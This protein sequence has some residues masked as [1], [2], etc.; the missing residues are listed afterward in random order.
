[1]RAKGDAYWAAQTQALLLEAQGWRS[2]AQGDAGSA[3]AS[4]RAA[5]DQEDAFE[6]LPLTPG[7][8][9]P[10]R[11]QLGEL[12]L[13]LN[14]PDQALQAFRAAL[15]EAPGRRG[16]LIGEITAAMV[17]TR[18]TVQLGPVVK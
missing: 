17:I 11:E 6:K 9:V 2:A 15:A 16:A 8:I 3:I 10:A 5:A 12:L 18:R 14:H 13:Q 4:L 1:L 7:P